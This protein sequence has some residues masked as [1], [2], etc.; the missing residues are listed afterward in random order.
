MKLEPYEHPY[1]SQ[2]KTSSLLLLLLF[3]LLLLSAIMSLTSCAEM[4]VTVS[5]D[6]QHGSYSYSEESGV[7]IQIDATK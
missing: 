6:G 7:Q 3:S 5:I 1:R 4:P 2:Y